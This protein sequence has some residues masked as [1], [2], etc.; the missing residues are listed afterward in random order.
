MKD[1]TNKTGLTNK[2]EFWSNLGEG[3][4][5]SMII[6]SICL[7]IGGCNY[8]VSSG[9]ATLEAG[10]RTIEAPASVQSSTNIHTNTVPQ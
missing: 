9:R 4:A 10:R 5:F 3:L 2:T 1:E 6:T 8:L 7:G